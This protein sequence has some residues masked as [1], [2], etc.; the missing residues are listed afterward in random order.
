M[1]RTL[2]VA[3]FF[4]RNNNQ[5]TE[6]RFAIYDLLRSARI[7]VVIFFSFPSSFPFLPLLL[8]FTFLTFFSF[9]IFLLFYFIIFLLFYFFY[10][11]TFFLFYFFTFLLFYFFLFASYRE[12]TINFV[13]LDRFPLKVLPYVTVIFIH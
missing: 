11:F 2:R 13:L 9:F 7:V 4:K 1:T 8:F 3:N 10:F 6:T 5:R 12:E